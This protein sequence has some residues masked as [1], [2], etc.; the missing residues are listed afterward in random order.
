MLIRDEGVADTLLSKG[1]VRSVAG[2]EA[3]V[4]TDRKELLANRVN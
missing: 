1:R 4:V 3:D 2:D